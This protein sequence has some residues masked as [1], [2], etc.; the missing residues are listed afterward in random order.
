ML[1][2]RVLDNY[3]KTHS[4]WTHWI[5]PAWW[6][7]ILLIFVFDQCRTNSTYILQQRCLTITSL[8]STKPTIRGHKANKHLLQYLWNEPKII[9]KKLYFS[10]SFVPA[11]T[12]TE[13]TR[14]N[15]SEKLVWSK[16]V[17]WQ[18]SAFGNNMLSSVFD[19]EVESVHYNLK[20]EF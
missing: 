5:F 16:M 9:S 12:W 17:N 15:S 7:L 14:S 2:P 11:Q 13:Y 19:L 20:E 8:H 3:F 1:A 10:S 4:R 18:L 6:F